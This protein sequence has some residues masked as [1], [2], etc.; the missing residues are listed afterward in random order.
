MEEFK[1]LIQRTHDAGL[2]VIIDIVPNHV[3]RNY[4]GLTNPE[5]V[6]DFGASD[7]TSKEYDVNN[8]F[9]YIPGE[10]FK[11]PEWQDGYLPLGGD[12]NRLADSKFEEVPA[13]WTG[14]DPDWPNPILT[15]GTKP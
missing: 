5:G 9:Y 1:E 11:V 6:E 7:D 10:A 2:K 15:I 13:K 3:A 12:D 8:N 14:N 4:K